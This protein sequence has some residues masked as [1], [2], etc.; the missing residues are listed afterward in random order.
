MNLKIN[1]IRRT[2]EQQTF[3]ITECLKN[4][5]TRD[6]HAKQAI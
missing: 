3:Y 6:K 2:K 5:Q 1:I 4:R